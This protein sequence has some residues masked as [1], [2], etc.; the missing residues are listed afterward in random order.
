MAARE[1]QYPLAAERVLQRLLADGAL[2]TH[3]CPFPS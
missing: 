1:L 2:A 3:E